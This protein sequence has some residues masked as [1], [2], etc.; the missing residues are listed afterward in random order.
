MFSPKRS[1]WP[2]ILFYISD[3]TNSSPYSGKSLR[4]K[5]QC[6]KIF[7]RTSLREFRSFPLLVVTSWSD[8][9]TIDDFRPSQLH[10]LIAVPSLLLK[11]KKYHFQNKKE[12]NMVFKPLFHQ[13]LNI[14]VLSTHN[15]TL[16]FFVLNMVIFKKSYKDPLWMHGC[17]VAANPWTNLYQPNSSSIPIVFIGSI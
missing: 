6:W 11:K 14:F 12:R 7:K 16:C 8:L 10:F 9:L 17:I 1:Q 3:I 5:N 4:K 15:L 13:H 2:L